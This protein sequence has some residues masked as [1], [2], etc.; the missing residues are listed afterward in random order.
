MQIIPIEDESLL[1]KVTDKK[2]ILK[3]TEE[4]KFDVKIFENP[5]DSSVNSSVENQK[6]MGDLEDRY[7]I[8]LYLK[9]IENG[10]I[11]KLESSNEKQLINKIF[12]SY[13]KHFISFT[14]Y[15]IDNIGN[16]KINGF[17][18]E[19]IYQYIAEYPDHSL[20]HFAAAF[21]CIRHFEKQTNASNSNLS[22]GQDL[23]NLVKINSENSNMTPL[24]AAL[25]SRYNMH[26]KKII[27]E[28][29]IVLGA[30]LSARDENG[31]TV[32][33]FSANTNKDIVELILS[34]IKLL[35]AK[36]DLYNRDNEGPH[37]WAAYFGNNEIYQLLSEFCKQNKKDSV[38]QSSFQIST[39]S[40]CVKLPVSK[41]LKKFGLSSSTS[42]DNRNGPISLFFHLNL[43][44]DDNP[45]IKKGKK[46]IKHGVDVNT[47]DLYENTPLQ[48]ICA[49]KVIK[50][51]LK[52]EWI[53]LL[54]T[55]NAKTDAKDKNGNTA[56]HYL[57][58]N[59]DRMGVK[60]LL[61][62]GA[63]PSIYNNNGRTPYQLAPNESMKEL[64]KNIGFDVNTKPPSPSPVFIK[65]GNTTGN[66]V[67]C[68]DGGGIKGLNS[69]EILDQIEKMTKKPIIDSF[70][71]VVG[72]STGGIIA[73][74]LAAGRTVRQCKNL[75]FELMNEIFG[76]FEC[77][78]SVRLENILQ[79]E[80][81]EMKMSCLKGSKI[82]VAI[83]ATEI[84]K[85][86]PE[87]VIYPNYE[88]TELNNN[89]YKFKDE[90]VSK[91]AKITSAAP[92]YFKKVGKSLDGGMLANN[93][94]LD[95]I[96]QVSKYNEVVQKTNKNMAH[97][98]VSIGTGF[99]LKKEDD[100]KSQSSGASFD[101]C[102][103]C[104]IC[105]WFKKCAL[106][107]DTHILDRIEVA[108]NGGSLIR[109]N[110]PL[111]RKIKINETNPEKLLNM[112][113]ETKVFM[114]QNREKIYEFMKTLNNDSSS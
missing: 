49:N 81:S 34:R 25:V 101:I 82:K 45:S 14:R 93:P 77:S 52:L 79:R 113:W 33:H 8:L 55:A 36:L 75:Y 76:I 62:F 96:V 98:V 69:L 48:L 111:T 95:A 21:G 13:D 84:I 83:T 70:E 1:E 9:D 91:V 68:L 43:K 42:F 54:L 29:L 105:K 92:C 40:P 102:K 12:D 18:L 66:K 39:D 80:F 57:V 31:N 30:D 4:E 94:T 10:H 73:L 106:K 89:N 107:K 5:L 51:R 65:I 22:Q 103:L 59:D 20:T 46:L 53:L 41:L 24:H 90:L 38:S 15:Y 99:W 74:A 86:E 104:K 32:L 67:L 58:S 71:W 78:N 88:I 110:P 37:D 17:Q 109:L 63:D 3:T 87:L 44:S 50:G 85:G 26:N 28:K 60:A 97:V 56:L 2:N 7:H 27:V 47:P 64:F 23:V 19:N 6:V 112:M 100:N 11:Y 72:T 16:D 108:V 61:A 35:T 114:Y